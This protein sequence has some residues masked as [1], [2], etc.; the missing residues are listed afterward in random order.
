MGGIDKG[1]D[2]API[3]AGLLE[4]GKKVIVVGPHGQRMA[5]E[6]EG[7]VSLT[8]ARD[9]P[10]GVRMAVASAVEGD[11]VLLSPAAASFDFFTG[12]AQR[13]EIFQRLCRE[14][15]RRLGDG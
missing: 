5:K 15:T 3:R 14:E 7:A 8:T 11:T 9:W 1:S 12:Y 10:E 6:L 13:G 4:K 2:Y